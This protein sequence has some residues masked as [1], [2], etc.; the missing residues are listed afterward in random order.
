MNQRLTKILKLAFIVHTIIL[1]A[2]FIEVANLVTS[3]QSLVSPEI[4]S[5]ET[6][7]SRDFNLLRR[8]DGREIFNL[9]IE[10]HDVKEYIYNLELEVFQLIGILIM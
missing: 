4:V 5:I 9:K 6:L 7:D 8:L 3:E 1:I 2:F 10:Q